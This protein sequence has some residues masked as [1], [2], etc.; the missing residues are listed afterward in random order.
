MQNPTPS[1]PFAAWTTSATCTMVSPPSVSVALLFS[2]SKGGCFENISQLMSL[3]CPK[4]S[5]GCPRLRMKSAVRSPAPEVSMLCLH[6]LLWPLSPALLPRVHLGPGLPAVTQICPADFCFRT[7]PCCP[8]IWNVLPSGVSKAP[9]L[10]SVRPPR[11]PPQVPAF[12]K[13]VL[14]SF[15][16]V[17]SVSLSLSRSFLYVKKIY[18]SIYTLHQILVCFLTHQ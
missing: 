15:S 16:I 14:S 12:H 6:G 17:L 7:H 2:P 1:N 5:G 8:S 13:F 10:I 11:S 18:N 9:S 3:L 4:G